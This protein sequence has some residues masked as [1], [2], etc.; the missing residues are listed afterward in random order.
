VALPFKLQAQS[1][2]AQ[3]AYKRFVQQYGQAEGERIFLQKAS[4]QG[5]GSTLRQKVN[6]IYHTGAKLK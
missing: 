6:S 4:E 5:K 2:G 1:K 3:K